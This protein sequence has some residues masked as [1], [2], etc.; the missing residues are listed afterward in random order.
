MSPSKLRCDMARARG[1][2]RFITKTTHP[3]R[4]SRS[5]QQTSRNRRHGWLLWRAQQHDEVPEDRLWLLDRIRRA[6]L[7][8]S[9]TLRRRFA[10]HPPVL[11]P[12]R[13]QRDILPCLPLAGFSLMP[14]EWTRQKW[15][16]LLQYLNMILAILAWMYGIPVDAP[17]PPRHTAVQQVAITNLVSRAVDF[18]K[19]LQLPKAGQWEH[20]LPDWVQGISRPAGP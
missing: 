2:H 16:V 19:R 18:V 3:C 6:A 4:R 13:R 9:S 8:S 7:A 14:S 5:S 20:L 17:P 15:R 11:P 10:A 12:G 1:H